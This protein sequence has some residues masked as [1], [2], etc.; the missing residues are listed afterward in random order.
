MINRLKSDS[1]NVGA[2][3]DCKAK[4]HTFTFEIPSALA[5]RFHNGYGDM[6]EKAVQNLRRSV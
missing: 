3:A 1:S 4:N 5:G 6:I 2:D